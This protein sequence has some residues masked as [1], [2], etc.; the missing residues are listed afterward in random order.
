MEWGAWRCLEGAL[1]VSHGCHGGALGVSFGALDMPWKHLGVS[2][3]CLGG[4]LV[5]AWGAI[6]LLWMD[7]TWG[8]CGCA[9]GVSLG[10]L[11]LSCGCL[12]GDMGALEMSCGHLGATWGLWKCHASALG[13]SYGGLGVNMRGLS[14]LQ[15]L[16]AVG[17]FGWRE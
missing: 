9:F 11:E 5:V 15:A 10:A 3:G 4:V 14:P 6:G 17:T 16:A 7:V 2:S 8:W 12:G 13:M 1:E